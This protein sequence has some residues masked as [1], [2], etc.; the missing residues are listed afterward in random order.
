MKAT[1]VLLSGAAAGALVAESMN[2]N[3]NRNG[4]F[5]W[6]PMMTGMTD[7]WAAVDGAGV[8]VAAEP[9][10]A[11]TSATATMARDRVRTRNRSMRGA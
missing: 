2:E 3:T 7:G 4:P 1:C 6:S 10:A 9:Q 8:G 11:A 5:T